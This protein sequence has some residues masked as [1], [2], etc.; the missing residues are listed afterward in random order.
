MNSR[1][2]QIRKENKMT[3]SEFGER[4]GVKGNTITGYE[5]GL[6]T[7]S[8][9]VILAIC[10]EFNINKNWLMTGDGEMYVGVPDETAE[11]VSD[12]LEKSN[13]LYDIIKG[14]MKTY[15]KLDPKSQ[16]TL[17]NFAEELLEELKK[18]G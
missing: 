8:D 17:K 4:I 1:I 11:I 3:Q 18:G 12:L 10:R 7:P 16:E 5:T 14:I 6:R 2:K 13:P 15:Q 9:A